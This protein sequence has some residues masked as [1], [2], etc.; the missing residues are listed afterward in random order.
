ME[1]HEFPVFRKLVNDRS[2]YRIDSPV[3]FMEVQ[4]MGQ[5]CVVHHVVANIYP[6][7][8]RIAEL[9][10]RTDP[11]V[12]LSDAEEFARWWSRTDEGR[13]SADRRP[14]QGLQ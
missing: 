8:V 1:R 12:V 9:L 13:T 14:S 3:E 11:A 5:R 10:E 7:R 2:F 4:R 6:E